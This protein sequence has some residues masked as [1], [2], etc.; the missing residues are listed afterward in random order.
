MQIT[1]CLDLIRE[2]CRCRGGWDTDRADLGLEV[3]VIYSLHLFYPA[4]NAR[5]VESATSGQ[6]RSW[7]VTEKCVVQNDFQMV[8]M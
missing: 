3:S 2:E 8:S 6:L 4:W 5:W 7:H 1:S